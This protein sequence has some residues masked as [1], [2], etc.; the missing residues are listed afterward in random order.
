M[1]NLDTPQNSDLPYVQLPENARAAA[2]D[3]LLKQGFTSLERYDIFSLSEN[4]PVKTNILAFA[5]PVHRTPDYTGLTVYNAANGHNDHELVKYL[6]RSAAP[7]HLIHRNDAFSFWGC[8]VQDGN[9]DPRLI[10]PHIAYDQL[11]N[12]L[13]EYEIDLKP[14][15]IIDV[16]QGR[17]TFTIFRDIQPLQLSFWAA[18]VTGDSLVTHFAATVTSLREN[19]NRL[20][21]LRKEA[22]D[23]LVTTLSIQLLGAIIL[24]D[25]GVLGDEMRRDEPSLDVLIQRANEKFERYFQ[26]GLFRKY[27]SEAIDAYRLLREVC[28]AGF[29]PDMLSELYKTA[30]SIQD[31]KVSGSYDTPLHLTRRI[32]HNIPVELIPPQKRTIADMTCGWG[33]FLVAGHERI[34]GLKDMENLTLRDHI[35][36]NDGVHFTSQLA[37]LGLLL[38]TSE[39][40]W[41]IDQSN[42]LDWQWLRTN[43]PTIIVGNPPFEADR[44]KTSPSRGNR[45]YEKAN[46]FLEY[47]LNRL[48]PGGYL[49]M[50]MPRSFIVAEASIGNETSHNLRKHLLETCDLFELWELPTNV[51]SDAT[52]RTIVLFAQKQEELRER[53]HFPVRVRTIQPDTYEHFRTTRELTVTASGLVEDQSVWNE[54]ARKSKGSQNTY[55]MDYTIVLPDYTWRA[56]RSF[57]EDLSHWTEVVFRG[58]IVGQKVENKQWKDD[59]NPKQVPWLTGVKS[60][61]PAAR[62]FFIDYT[63]ATTITYPNNLER[64]RKSKNAAKNKEHLLAAVKVLVPYDVDPSWGKRV[65][66]AIERK[67]YY[68]SDHFYIVVPNSMAQ[69]RSITHEVI[70]AV[71]NWDVSNAWVVEHL[72]SPAIPKRIMDTIPFP[73]AL[74]VEDCQILT[75]A[76]LQLEAAAYANQPE[77]TEATQT[78]DF[79][80]KRAYRLD[81]ETF[82]RLRLVKEWDSKPHITLDLQ[83]N[84]AEANWLLSG[85]VHNVDVSNG[86]ITLWMSGFSDL[87]TVQIM[88]SM[89]GWMFR[90]GAAFR[91]KIPR[92]YVKYGIIDGDANGWGTFFPQ[93]YAYMTEEELFA[94][95][96]DILHRDDKRRV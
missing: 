52:A 24:A 80:L 49:A 66:V 89:P 96:A 25:T 55:L 29:A 43:R 5:H 9:P 94:E 1:L 59:P 83:P 79:I 65:R 30:Y 61:M 91:T 42:A 2:L 92:K 18:E 63:K 33:S 12:V 77:P 68:V 82:T 39:D 46:Q 57:C 53:S 56:I 8:P 36:G 87:Q 23:E 45:R 81:D 74:S 27:S 76:V 93:T 34:S 14:Q 7:F 32:W 86:T 71:L 35:Y 54:Q 40:S 51:F 16:K 41:H 4:H 3:T 10:A 31:R 19:I 72:K 67:G 44:R 48:A 88:P 84:S 21:G 78:I 13:G 85:I 75:Q 69:R 50:I 28:Y 47:S 26:I 64:P 37:G 95:L 70:A 22:K 6:A 17:D 90:P 62:P 15:R 58:A 38:S 60:A 73:K 20:G 11:D